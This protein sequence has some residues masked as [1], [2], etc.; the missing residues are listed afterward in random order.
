MILTKNQCPE[1]TKSLYTVVVL[2]VSCDFGLGSK[3][4]DARAFI[5]RL[6]GALTIGMRGAVEEKMEDKGSGQI[7]RWR[8]GLGHRIGLGGCMCIE[9]I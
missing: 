6:E 3:I 2:L 8:N 5:S 7:F 4:P 9:A 1:L